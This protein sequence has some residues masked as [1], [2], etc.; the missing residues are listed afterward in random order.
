MAWGINHQVLDRETYLPVLLK[1]WNALVKDAV[2]PD[3]FLGWVQGTG[4]E[5]QDGQPVTY[6]KIPNFEDYGVGCFLLGAS[7]VYKMRSDK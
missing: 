4:K 5:P 2:H 7:E 1:G 6:N 3:G